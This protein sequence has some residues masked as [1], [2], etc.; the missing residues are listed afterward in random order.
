MKNKIKGNSIFAYVA[1][2]AATIIFLEIL[3][4]QTLLFLSSYDSSMN[5][6]AFALL[7][8][9]IGALLSYILSIKNIKTE[10]ITNICFLLL[11]LSIPASFASFAIFSTN[12][13]NFMFV[14]ML[15]FIFGSCII[16]SAFMSKE[17]N[18]I[19]FFDLFGAGLGAILFAISLEYLGMEISYFLIFCVCS[20]FGLLYSVI[21]S[22]VYSD[23]KFSIQK[24]ILYTLYLIFLVLGIYACVIQKTT[25]KLN[26]V[27]LAAETSEDTEKKIFALF[28]KNRN[29]LLIFTHS[30]LAGRIDAFRVKD[31][32]I[33]VSQDGNLAGDSLKEKKPEEFNLDYRIP[34]DLL[35]KF[36]NPKTF[37]VGTSAEG[38]I[39]PLAGVGKGEMI[40]VEL[41]PGKVKFMQT[42][43]AKIRSFDAYKH[44]K[45]L[46][47]I[48]ARTYLK[49][50]H[51][52]FDQITLM[53]SHTSDFLLSTRAPEYTHTVEAFNEYF[54]HLTDNGFLNI[55]A[56]YYYKEKYFSACQSSNDKLLK[57]II[58]ALEKRGISEPSKNIYIFDWIWYRQYLVKKNPFTPD[59]LKTLDS[60]LEKIK[61]G[62][63]GFNPPTLVSHP[64]MSEDVYEDIFIYKSLPG[65]S[66]L[67]DNKPFPF[68]TKEKDL[69]ASK[70]FFNSLFTD[71]AP[72]LKISLYAL[73]LA[74]LP[75]CLLFFRHKTSEKIKKKEK[76][77][78]LLF[79]G[80][81]GLGYLLLEIVLM[82]KYQL[83]L[84]SPA[85]SLL[86][87]TAGMLILSGI[88][89]Y[90]SSYINTKPKAL[91]LFAG[92]VIF[93]LLA[94]LPS[95]DIF[96]F[97][98]V[99]LRSLISLFSIAPLAFLLGMPFPIALFLLSNL[100]SLPSLSD[101]SLNNSH[102]SALMFSINGAFS[103][104]AAPI[105]SQVAA[106]FGFN[107]VFSLGTFIYI[108]LAL[109][110]LALWGNTKRTILS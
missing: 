17:A 64:K 98:S 46:E 57:T 95:L 51:E 53:N 81:S 6:L 99:F 109:L 21:Y 75:T 78:L 41:V 73:L 104:I 24:I 12:I 69:S 43:E 16:S 5:S 32:I 89:G 94:M 22:P 92:I 87:I 28:K 61:K 13:N 70:T 27:R 30:S 18:K 8:I 58:N 77:L 102:N 29:N 45:S 47:I 7:G 82:Q 86:V 4:F 20:L 103:A 76:I 91:V 14:L 107:A 80:L 23:R 84:G 93:S 106:Y 34:K 59:E 3:F 67:T 68:W 90:F 26:L 33:G 42:E 38:I 56:I 71:I 48:D 85:V 72:T 88:G 50:S 2:V 31:R 62:R 65:Y 100:S 19:Y 55:E 15:P 63:K 1:V 105:A 37:I 52:K 60:W 83:Y 54:D 74:I 101:K 66:P 36:E 10:K 44:L 35:I 79:S 9:S 49:F 39:N 40:G 11:T 96:L 110:F 108:I 25:D 97:K